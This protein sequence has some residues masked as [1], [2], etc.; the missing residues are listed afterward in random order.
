MFVGIAKGYIR[1]YKRIGLHVLVY[2]VTEGYVDFLGGSR[3]EEVRGVLTL[4]PKP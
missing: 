3:V 1:A 4:N 2:R